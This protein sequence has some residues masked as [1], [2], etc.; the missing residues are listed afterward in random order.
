MVVAT[1]VK[2]KL[3]VRMARVQLSRQIKKEKKECAGGLV[4]SSHNRL[5]SRRP[6]CSQEEGEEAVGD[7][8]RR[9]AAACDACCRVALAYR[10]YSHRTAKTKECVARRLAPA[11]AREQRAFEAVPGGAAVRRPEVAA[12]ARAA[13]VLHKR[14]RRSTRRERRRR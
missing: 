2:E 13:A 10:C 6:S 3:A 4:T 5:L 12:D 14:D 11:A 9:K 7:A 8:R 1:M